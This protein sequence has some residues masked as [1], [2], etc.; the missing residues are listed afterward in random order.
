MDAD[1]FLSGFILLFVCHQLN[2]N[3]TGELKNNLFQ[4]YN[5]KK[6]DLKTKQRRK[7]IKIEVGYQWTHGFVIK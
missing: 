6:S 4:I 5:L 2:R 1:S 3:A 7:S